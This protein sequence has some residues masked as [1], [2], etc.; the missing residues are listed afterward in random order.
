MEYRA[1]KTGIVH[2]LFGKSEF[3]GDDLLAN[4][5]AVAVNFLSEFTSL[6]SLFSHGYFDHQVDLTSLCVTLMYYF[7]KYQR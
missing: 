7:L 2:V 3:S 5:V 4:L 1:D 6:V